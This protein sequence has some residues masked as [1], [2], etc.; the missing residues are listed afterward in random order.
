MERQKFM[1]EFFKSEKKEAYETFD[2]Y[3][4]QDLSKA[5]D[6]GQLF[7]GVGSEEMIHQPLVF[8]F[9]SF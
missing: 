4:H 8:S 3:V 5:F 9:Q 7:L 1:K 2:S 6:R